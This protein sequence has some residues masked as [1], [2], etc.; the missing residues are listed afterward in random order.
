MRR[1]VFFLVCAAALVV[2]VVVLASGGEGS[3]FDGVVRSI[4]HTYHVRATRIPFM[5]LAS[6][7]SGASTSGGVRNL[8]LAQF[9][10]FSLALDG[11]DLTSMVE[12]KLG[13]SW[14]RVVRETSRGGREQTLVF[15]R[16]EG[17]RMGLF[18]LD[19]DGGELDVVEVSVNPDRLN[20]TVNQY[21][22]HHEDNE[23]RPD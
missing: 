12:Q 4:E 11:E 21:T 1:L 17:A 13:P 14:A 9:E 7:I 5:G 16:P 6:L 2:P 8:H 15:M 23:D 19:S 22:H 20:A 18:V 3:G 10:N